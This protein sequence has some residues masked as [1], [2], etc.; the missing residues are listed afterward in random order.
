[1][2]I[3]GFYS[4]QRILDTK[5]IDGNTPELFLVTSNKSAG[6]TTAFAKKLI[7]DFINKKHQFIVY[8]R[9]ANE[10]YDGGIKFYNDVS[11]LFFSEYDFKQ[12]IQGAGSYCEIKINDETAGW[13]LALNLADKLKRMS[14][15]FN[16]AK[17]IF[18]DEFQ[19]E[20]NH[21][22]PSELTKFY[23]LH[24]ALARGN[25]QQRRYLPIYMCS[26]PY[27]LLNPYFVAL[28]ISQRLKKDTKILKGHGFVLENDYIESAAKAMETSGFVKAFKS[29]NSVELNKYAQYSF[30]GVY[31]DDSTS[32]I[33]KLSGVSHYVMTI[34]YNGEMY[35]I[36]FFPQQCLFYCDDRYDDTFPLKIAFSADDINTEFVYKSA[37]FEKI[38]NL[39]NAFERGKFRFK[40]AM[41]KNV[42]IN[43]L[44][45]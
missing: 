26:N 27:S 11:R 10:I 17:Q 40:N 8:Y 5:D 24:T 20:T 14:H 12:V 2:E 3:N 30:Q 22:C 44:K 31:M 19:S 29:G 13:C 9:F 16:N 23:A 21:Y 4:P 15:F 7:D 38:K 43:I 6:K 41:C 35:A 37:E 33:E 42:I 36:R 34:V 25:G 32:L 39:R 18:F 28:G 45:Y 1:M